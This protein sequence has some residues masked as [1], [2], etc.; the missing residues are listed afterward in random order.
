MLW[1]ERR[2]LYTTCR[3]FYERWRQAT[4]YRL[5]SKLDVDI[6]VHYFDWNCCWNGGCRLWFIPSLRWWCR[7][8]PFLMMTRALART[9]L[10]SRVA[11]TTWST[12]TTP[13]CFNTT[14]VTHLK[15]ASTESLNNI[16]HFRTDAHLYN[17]KKLF[18][19]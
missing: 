11:T 2:S 5:Q 17:A 6:S 13:I 10:F 14:S 15:Q 16:T 9:I 19:I 12:I 18:S 4:P 1:W 3:T 8:I 7:V